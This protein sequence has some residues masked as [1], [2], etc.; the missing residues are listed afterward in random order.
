MEKRVAII[1]GSK[2]DLNQCEKGLKHLRAFSNIE[3]VGV[4]VRSQH[5][6]TLETQ[7]LLKNL[8]NCDVDVA[9][10]GAGWA[11]H[12]TGCCDAYL[13]YTLRT[14][15][16][17]IIGVAFADKKNE[18]HTK[19]AILSISEVPGTQVIFKDSYGTEL[20]GSCGFLDACI[21][22]TSNREFSVIKLPEPK[23]WLDFSLEAAITEA[24]L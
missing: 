3:V 2:S 7:E 16:M 4:F 10:V 18:N 12:L 23:A 21:M 1:V 20:V 9:I 13:R 24:S 15:K 5:R 17:P 6:N 8:V 14:T 22:I 19:A 11:N